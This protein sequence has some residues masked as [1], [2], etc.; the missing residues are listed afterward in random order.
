MSR[1]IDFAENY[2]AAQH[3]RFPFMLCGEQF[4]QKY[5][6]MRNSRTRRGAPQGSGKAW[7]VA[8]AR[9]GVAGRGEEGRIGVG[10]AG[11]TC[12]I[13]MAGSG[14]DGLVALILKPVASR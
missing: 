4:V 9:A 8:L 3:N 5:D 14:R 6:V 2:V 1:K 11:V 13:D 10:G 7:R 12:R